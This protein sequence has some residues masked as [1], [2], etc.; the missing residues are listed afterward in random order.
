[1]SDALYPECSECGRTD[2]IYSAKVCHD[3]EEGRY[4]VVEYELECG[5]TLTDVEAFMD[6]GIV[7]LFQWTDPGL[8]EVVE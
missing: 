8:I 3:S 1:M 7:E 5:H 4:E 6:E 2:G